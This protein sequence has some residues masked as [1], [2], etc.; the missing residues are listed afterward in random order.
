MTAHFRNG[1]P[2]ASGDLYGGFDTNQVWD[3]SKVTCKHC[4]R[5]KQYGHGREKRA[6]KHDWDEKKDCLKPKFA[7]MYQKRG[8]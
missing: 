7:K 1:C 5:L 4:L 2:W 8:W 6:Q 3:W